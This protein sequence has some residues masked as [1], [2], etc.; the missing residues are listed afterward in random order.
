[1]MCTWMNILLTT[2][3]S[4]VQGT[5]ATSSLGPNAYFYGWEVLTYIRYLADAY[6]RQYSWQV[7]TSLTIITLSSLMII[8]LSIVFMRHMMTRNAKDRLYELC[9]ARFEEPFRQVLKGTE[10]YPHE[11]IEYICK[12]DTSALQTFDPA[13]FAR[14]IVKL[15]LERSSEV[16]L[17]N[18]QR[19]CNMTGVQAYLEY[20]MVKGHHVEETLQILMTLPIRISEGALAAYTGSRNSRTRDLARSYFGFCSKTEPFHYVMQDANEPFQMWYPTMLHRLV[21]WHYAKGHPTPQ[22]LT[23]ARQSENSDRRALFISEIPYW[24][25]EREKRGVQAYLTSTDQKCRSAAIQALAIIGDPDSENEL[26]ANYNSQFPQAKRET[27]LAVAKINTGRQTEFFKQAYLTSSSQ[28]TR[29]VALSCL[30]N[31]GP[32]G[33]RVFHELAHV[34]LDDARFFEQIE[35]AEHKEKTSA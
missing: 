25:S 17:P 21:G 29:A 27:L 5:A 23:L 1:M 2:G 32:E 26:V 31:Y 4:V 8:L 19:L 18:M 28:N 10:K 34:G 7:Q 20:N 15:R 16:F 3:L 22:F 35:S 9:C 24:G 11:E 30:F 13:T 12:V 33:R 14:L 6:L